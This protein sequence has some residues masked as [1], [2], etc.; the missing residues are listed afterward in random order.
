MELK[1]DPRGFLNILAG[2][3]TGALFARMKEKAVRA[4]RGKTRATIE[5][6]RFLL[7][8]KNIHG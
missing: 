2:D 8:H 7:I 3:V 4:T 5:R 1:V 6:A